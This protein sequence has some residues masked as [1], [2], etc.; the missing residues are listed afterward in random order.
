[1]IPAANAIHDDNPPLAPPALRSRDDAWRAGHQPLAI[2]RRRS[3]W[4]NRRGFRGPP[5]DPVKTETTLA[6]RGTS[7]PPRRSGA[8]GPTGPSGPTGL[9]GAAGPT[10]AGVNWVNVAEEF[11]ADPTGGTDSTA[12]IRNAIAYLGTLSNQTTRTIYFPTGIYLVQEGPIFIDVP[13]IRLTGDTWVGDHVVKGS[14]LRSYNKAV[15]FPTLAIG[16]DIPNPTYVQN[17]NFWCWSVPAA[18]SIPYTLDGGYG[19]MLSEADFG[20]LNGLPEFTIEF[21]IEPLNAAVTYNNA[22]ILSS[23][24]AIDNLTSTSAFNIAFY[25]N[26]G[27]G[28][29]R[30][31]CGVTTTGGTYNL[32]S[33]SSIRTFPVNTLTHFAISYDGSMIRT[34]VGGVLDL[35]TSA[36]GT[37]LQGIGE[38]VALT[39]YTS[40]Y[41]WP[42]A[43]VLSI[44]EIAYNIASVR[45][46]NTCLYT[47]SFDPGTTKL[48]ATNGV[49]IALL[50]FD[51]S[52]TTSLPK[53]G[54]LTATSAASFIP[55]NFRS[56]PATIWLRFHGTV[57]DYFPGV[58]IDHLTIN[59]NFSDGIV[60]YATVN[61]TL[62]ELTFYYGW[63]GISLD[64]FSYT[65]SIK[66]IQLVLNA[67]GYTGIWSWGLGILTGA[68]FVSVDSVQFVNGNWSYVQGNTSTASLSNAYFLVGSFGGLYLNGVNGYASF[69]GSDIDVSDEGVACSYA[70]FFLGTVDQFQLYGSGVGLSARS[71]VP[72]FIFSGTG[73]VVL[74]TVVHGGNPSGYMRFLQPASIPVQICGNTEPF[75]TYGSN[76]DYPWIDTSSSAYSFGPVYVQT[77][78][79]GGIQSI[80]AAVSGAPINV[81]TNEFLWGTIQITDRESLLTAPT[82]IVLPTAIVGYVRNILN[83]TSQPLVITNAESTFSNFLPPALQNTKT[84]IGN[85]FFPIHN[86]AY[87][88]YYGTLNTSLVFPGTMIEFYD[89]LGHFYQIEEVLETAILL[90][91]EYTGSGDVYCPGYYQTIINAGGKFI[92]D[93]VNWQ[94]ENNVSA[95]GLVGPATITNAAGAYAGGYVFVSGGDLLTITGTNLLPGSLFSL[96]FDGI[97]CTNYTWVNSATVTC[98]APTMPSPGNYNVTSAINGDGKAITISGTITIDFLWDPSQ[99]SNLVAY[100]VVGVANDGYT[101]VKNGSVVSWCPRAGS[102]S[103]IFFPYY[104]SSFETAYASSAINGRP[105]ITSAST[106]QLLSKIGAAA[107]YSLSLVAQLSSLPTA[108][109]WIVSAYSDNF[110]LGVLNVSGSYDF[111]AYAGPGGAPGTLS[112]PS[113]STWTNP[114]SMDALFSTA[115]SGSVAGYVN[116]SHLGTATGIGTVPELPG[117]GF[118]APS[119]F[120]GYLASLI[121][122]S[123]NLS[124]GDLFNLSTW[125]K[126][127]FGVPG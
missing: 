24:G 18:G 100:F 16:N 52:N 105:A 51:P 73:Q 101:S 117:F 119:A 13:G 67:N 120:S 41:G 106:N 54:W 20:Y 56:S 76:P 50:N 27:D 42:I 94:P 22:N 48:T 60:S 45:I 127:M 123:D 6:A 70:A 88:N 49:T 37:L 102:L 46:S 91:K 86:S 10:G 93:G 17:G 38:T 110:R 19:W 125:R 58:E 84:N 90:T 25:N 65:G 68:Q 109:T 95:Y 121:M 126:K 21:F 4:P 103:N 116:G 5:R 47:T 2:G 107:P 98:V 30:M 77:Q 55:N 114:F 108:D 29:I 89:Q 97:P 87:V 43:E 83:A 15:I 23:R 115:S 36:T 11:G 61:F 69:V 78:E 82:T 85:A 75:E 66:N 34:F 14:V 92:S 40:D 79:M 118:V 81:T 113:S 124:A 99:L 12:A 32:F 7:P 1:M 62:H 80:N 26:T 9:T 35:C 64:A 44:S 59:A 31:S 53:S 63:R 72:C 74:D 96:S 28:S 122:T 57:K 33:N 39:P 71:D 112:G 8:V 3:H 111:Y 104:G